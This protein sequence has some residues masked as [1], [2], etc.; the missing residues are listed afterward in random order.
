MQCKTLKGFRTW[1]DA[2]ILFKEQVLVSHNKGSQQILNRFKT[3]IFKSLFRSFQKWKQSSNDK[4]YE[5]RNKIIMDDDKCKR[6]GKIVRNKH[7]TNLR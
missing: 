4:S 5:N 2:T 1:K 7:M 3:Q 6:L